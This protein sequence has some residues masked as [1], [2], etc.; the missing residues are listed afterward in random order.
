MLSQE[1]NILKVP[2]K[3]QSPHGSSEQPH[4]ICPACNS[5]T[6]V[7]QPPQM[8]SA[9][10]AASPPPTLEPSLTTS[11]TGIPSHP[12]HEAGYLCHPNQGLIASSAQLDVTAIAIP[13]QIVRSLKGKTISHLTC[14]EESW[15]YT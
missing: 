6:R 5:M 1:A 10:G 4:A 3:R 12:E 2:G 9:S 8:R 14:T 11:I 15:K 7:S 13:L